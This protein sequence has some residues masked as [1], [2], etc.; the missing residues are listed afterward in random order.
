MRHHAI[1]LDR[2]F[3]ATK[4][5]QA[6]DCIHRYGVNDRGEVICAKTPTTIE[7]VIC[8]ETIDDVVHQNLARK[9]RRMYAWLNDPSLAPALGALN[10]AVSD[11][12]LANI[13]SQTGR[14]EVET[15]Q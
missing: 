1:F 5:M 13:F 9:Q 15:E 12:E 6:I 7:I 8:P 11:E 3:D 2:N 14:E 10:P 4:F